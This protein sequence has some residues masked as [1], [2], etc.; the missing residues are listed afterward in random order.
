MCKTPYFYEE[1]TIII[2]SKSKSGV[3][4]YSKA[5]AG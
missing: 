1:D 3:F 2:F 4:K 5:D